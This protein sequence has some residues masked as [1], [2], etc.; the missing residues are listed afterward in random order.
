[1]VHVQVVRG[2]ERK[3]VSIFDLVVGDVVPLS[4]GGQVNRNSDLSLSVFLVFL[5]RGPWIL[6]FRLYIERWKI[7]MKYLFVYLSCGV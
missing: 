7:C 2:G 4:I 3:Q 5:L 6:M 1:M